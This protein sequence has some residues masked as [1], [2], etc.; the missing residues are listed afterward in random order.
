MQTSTTPVHLPPASLQSGGSDPGGGDEVLAQEASTL[1]LDAFRFVR[2]LRAQRAIDSMP[3]G[4]LAVLAVLRAHGSHT[5]TA[6]ADHER[7]TSPS[8]NRIVNCLVDGGLVER[9]ADET[10]RRKVNILLTE[11]GDEIVTE[12]VRRREEWLV[13]A[14]GELSP[15]ERETLTAAAE[16]MGRIAK[17]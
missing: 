7:V 12:T 1:R 8:M 9:V 10:D 17:R 15:T 5:L 6:L 11:Q 4:Q 14:L 16:I 3:D 2:R 13:Q